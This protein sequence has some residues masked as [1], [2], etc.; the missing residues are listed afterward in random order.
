MYQII[1]TSIN[2]LLNHKKNK[3]KQKIT[4]N[5]SRRMNKINGKQTERKDDLNEEEY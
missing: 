4:E 2:G 3:K 1:I 5:K